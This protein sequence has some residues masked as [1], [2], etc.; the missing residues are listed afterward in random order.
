MRTVRPQ[1]QDSN[2][3]RGRWII[4]GNLASYFDTVHHRLLIRCVPRR[5]QDKR[6]ISLLWRILKAGHVDHGLFRA[7]S[8]GVP[9]G[10]V[11]SPLLSNI[12]LHEFVKWLEAKYLSKKARKDRWAW[13]FG[14][15]K[16]I[17]IAVRKNRQWKQFVKNAAPFW[18]ASSN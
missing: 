15:Q 1:L 14:I 6:F 3:V 2:C 12:M 10:G 4:E 18:K 11:L 8:Q 16:A 9:Q 17:P 7:A 13:N 5:V